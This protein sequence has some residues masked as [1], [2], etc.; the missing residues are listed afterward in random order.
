MVTVIIAHK[1]YNEYLKAAIKSCINQ[2]I[3]VNYVVIDDGSDTPPDPPDWPVTRD[4][5]YKVYE[6]DN[7]KFVYLKESLGPSMARNVGIIEAWEYSNYFQILDADDEM[8]PEKCEK[9]LNAFDDKI[10]RAHV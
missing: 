9:F 1:N 8:L 7:N 10:G 5:D 3:A 2:T 4:D 6:L